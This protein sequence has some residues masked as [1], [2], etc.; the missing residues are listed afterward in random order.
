MLTPRLLAMSYEELKALWSA[1]KDNA[2]ELW[3]MFKAGNLSHFNV[4]RFIDKVLVDAGASWANGSPAALGNVI[5]ELNARKT[6]AQ[7]DL[8][9]VGHSIQWTARNISLLFDIIAEFVLGLGGGLHG[10]GYSGHRS[11]E[12]CYRCADTFEMISELVSLEDPCAQTFT[13]ATYGALSATWTTQ[14]YITSAWDVHEYTRCSVY[15]S[16]YCTQDVSCY[17][18][19]DYQ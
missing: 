6:Q 4:F 10:G 17:D 1:V 8:A 3:D 18:W 7:Q 12:E 16:F 13:A 19:S 2:V 5:A 14:G 11:K 9:A 15:K